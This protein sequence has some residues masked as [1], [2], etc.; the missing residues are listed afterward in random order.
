MDAVSKGN[1][2]AESFIRPK[3]LL[4]STMPWASGARLAIGLSRVGCK[5]SALCAS[6]DPL[7]KTSAVDQIFPYS[8]FRPL[9]SVTAAI[10]VSCPQ[11]VVPC[12]DRAVHHLHELYKFRPSDAIAALI[13][14]SLAIRTVTLLPPPATVC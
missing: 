12:D 4:A 13:E 2:A 6:K 11:V 10:E 8:G 3:I 1:Q 5:I 7:R 9:R 14:R